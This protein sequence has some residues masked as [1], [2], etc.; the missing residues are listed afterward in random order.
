MQPAAT[1]LPRLLHATVLWAALAGA[2][3]AQTEPVSFAGK[4]IKLLIGYSP[5]GYG[6]D[7]YGR[8]LARYLGRHLPGNPAIVPQNR[9]GAGSLNLA[10]YLYNAAPK[11]GT[12]IA[13][14]GRGVAMDPLLAGNASNAAFDATKF[15]WLG[16][17]NNEVSG[18]YIRQPGPAATLQE[19]LAG[20]A[21]RVGATG[22]GGDQQVFTAAINSLLGT[23]LKTIA[24]Y[25][26]TNEILLAVERGELDGVVGFSWGVA[27]SGKKALLQAGKL[28]IVMQLGLAKHHELPDVPLVTEFVTKGDDMKVVE[29]IFSRQSM[30]R[31]LIAPPGIDPR[32]GEALRRAF[33]DAM[34]DA[35][36]VAEAARM[37]LE[38]NFV[39][40]AGVQALV[41]RLYRTPPDVIAR[42][43]AIASPH[44]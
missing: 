28:K 19:I 17:M 38:I 23:S 35:A 9:P 40:G 26:G 3:Q 36:L 7:T 16:S 39:D 12:E 6:Y 8:L 11:D 13:I 37:D 44:Q 5:S 2:A 14:V 10:N 4:Q 15:V 34:H 42:A 33:A 25:P 1:M 31:P 22:A 29:L 20:T 32:V 41:E 18:F 43:Q 24:G 30:G 27:R 21:L